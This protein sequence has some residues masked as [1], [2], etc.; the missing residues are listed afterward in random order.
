MNDGPAFS[1]RS[2]KSIAHL[3]TFLLSE[4]IIQPNFR[5]NLGSFW[6]RAFNFVASH[7]QHPLIANDSIYHSQMRL[8]RFLFLCRARDSLSFFSSSFFPFRAF[9]KDHRRFV[10]SGFWVLKEHANWNCTN[11]T[12]F[13]RDHKTHGDMS[14]NVASRSLQSGPF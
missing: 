13:L 1:A 4:R 11:R 2:I 10:V 5:R 8:F 3:H 6:Q 7:N 9:E 14:C 12:S